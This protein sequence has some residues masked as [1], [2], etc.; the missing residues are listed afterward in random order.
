MPDLSFFKFLHYETNYS[1]GAGISEGSSGEEG[2]SSGMISGSSSGVGFSGAVDG[3]T[4]GNF[5]G[6]GISEGSVIFFFLAMVQ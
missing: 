5:S 2:S 6:T 3:C 4:S 1:S